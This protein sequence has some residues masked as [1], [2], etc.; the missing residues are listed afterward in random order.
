MQAYL[1]QKFACFNCSLSCCIPCCLY[2][3]NVWNI[4]TSKK[5][6]H[7]RYLFA[8]IRSGKYEILNR[9]FFYPK[10]RHLVAI[11]LHFSSSFSVSLQWVAQTARQHC[12]AALIHSYTPTINRE[13]VWKLRPEHPLWNGCAASCSGNVWDHRSPS[14]LISSYAESRWSDASPF[15]AFSS[16]FCTS[17]VQQ[18]LSLFLFCV[19][20]NWSRTRRGSAPCPKQTQSTF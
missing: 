16:S 17:K 19:C 4:L 13:Q 1:L 6:H 5:D 18:L 3:G 20:L 14:P 15:S 9:S 7:K 11:L 2:D 8:L 10:W 12:R